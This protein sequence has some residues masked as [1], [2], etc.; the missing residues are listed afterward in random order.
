MTAQKNKTL[1]GIGL[2][3]TAMLIFPFLDVMAKK[4]GQ[5]GM[6]VMETVWARLFLGALMTL[7]ILYV[8]EGRK[9]LVLRDVKLNGGRAFFIV[10]TTFLFFSAMK[11]QGVA[12]TL[13]IYFIQP[14][15]ITAL[16]PIF[17]KEKVEWRRWMAVAI[18]FFGV[19][20]IIR[21]GLIA[22]NP[23]TL[24]AFGSGCASAFVLLISRK[25]AGNS[26][27][28]A[29]TFYTSFLGGL[30]ATAIMLTQWQWPTGTQWAMMFGLSAIGTMAN[31]LVIRGFEYCE[32]SL[33]APF[34]YAEMINA[35]TAGW[36]F[37]GDFP[38]FFT[39]VGVAILIACA[40]W[41]SNHERKRSAQ[42]VIDPGRV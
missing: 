25:L 21:P 9:A 20:V 12:E 23:G 22:F 42:E 17:L 18:G 36:Y 40:L 30:M 19:L 27:A 8:V 29:N 1:L 15:M 24:L 11:F 3:V 41:I 37:F 35:V 26:S 31:Y 6:P 39:F 32:A 33:L 10:F 13:S 16:A 34:G 2:M 4:L 28:L 38:D 14:I 5:Q 7:P